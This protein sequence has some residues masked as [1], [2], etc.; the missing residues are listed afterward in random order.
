M[1]PETVHAI[2]VTKEKL[3]ISL[4]TQKGR[5]NIMVDHRAT[6]AHC[7]GALS[8]GYTLLAKLPIISFSEL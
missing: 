5:P 4:A 6:A 2:S 7:V 8:A 3:N 1:P